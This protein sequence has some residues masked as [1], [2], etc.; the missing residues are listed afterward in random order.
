M[1][2]TIRESLE[3]ETKSLIMATKEWALCMS[4]DK[5]KNEGSTELRNCSQV[6]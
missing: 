1:I 2:I 4:S 3:R 6:L 5:I